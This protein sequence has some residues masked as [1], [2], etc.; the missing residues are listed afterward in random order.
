MRDD[1]SASGNLAGGQVG[2]W[3][4][5]AW[6]MPDYRPLAEAFAANLTE[7]RA[8]YHLW[9]KP[10]L[11]A[12]NTSRKPSV[13]LETMATYPGALHTLSVWP[14]KAS[15]CWP[16]A[17]SQMRALRSS[18]AVTMR[19]PSGLNAALAPVQ[20]VD[21][22]PRRHIPDASAARRRGHDPLAIGAE[23]RARYPESI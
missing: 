4:V 22:L 8:P 1:L 18:D 2:D 3:L 7:H 15:I 21:L 13:V 16:V 6:F 17:A 5:T 23:R 14:C 19:R 12:W 10:S 20:S 9:A 11:G